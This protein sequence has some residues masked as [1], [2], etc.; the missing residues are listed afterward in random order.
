MKPIRQVYFPFFDSALSLFTTMLG[1]REFEEDGSYITT[2]WASLLWLPLIPL[3][4]L[5]VLDDVDRTTFLDRTLGRFLEMF[6]WEGVLV[7]ERPLSFRQALTTYVFVSGLFIGAW[8]ALQKAEDFVLL[9]IPWLA[10]P[11]ILR[12]RARVTAKLMRICPDCAERVPREA[13]IC[14]AC[15]YRFDQPGS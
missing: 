7:E 13:R 2:Q 14:R 15:G 8:L 9:L 12:R 10:F 4:S 6:I 5:R 3:R 1:R 11:A